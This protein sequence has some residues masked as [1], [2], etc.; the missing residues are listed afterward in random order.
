MS[1]ITKEM[2]KDTGI[3]FGLVMLYIGIVAENSL[4][5][6]L[7]F[8]VFL[9]S[10]LIPAIFT[11][12]AVVWFKISEIL[13]FIVSKIVL[14]V[15]Y[16]IVV[17]PVSFIRKIFGSDPMMINNFGKSDKGTWTKREHQYSNYDF[18]K[19]F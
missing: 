18:I 19:P 1:R 12:P 5:L 16:L 7:S 15:I 8:A 6:K 13:G 11:Y 17:L 3:V 4:L 9:S 2:R 14:A 10:I